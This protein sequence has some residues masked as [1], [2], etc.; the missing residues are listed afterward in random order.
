MMMMMM[1]MTRTIRHRQSS[2]GSSGE[3]RYIRDSENK[4]CI[5]Y[6]SH[7]RRCLPLM[8]TPLGS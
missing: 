2:G 5:S 1:M 8:H 6:T 3:A 7:S 4:D